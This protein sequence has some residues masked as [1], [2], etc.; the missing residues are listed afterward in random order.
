MPRSVEHDYNSE[1]H[2]SCRRWRRR[3]IFRGKLTMHTAFER[4]DN[5]SPAAVTAVA[6]SR[7]HRSVLIGDARGRVFAWTLQLDVSSSSSSAAAAAAIAS[8]LAGSPSPNALGNAT[9]IA[10]GPPG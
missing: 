4:A 8:C 5:R 10:G 7:D 3:L 2:C 9:G 6:I 1:V